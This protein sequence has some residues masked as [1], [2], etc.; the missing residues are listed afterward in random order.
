VRVAREL[1]A[2]ADAPAAVLELLAEDAVSQQDF[3]AAAGWYRRLTE[4]VPDRPLY[5]RNLYLML[6]NQGRSDDQVSVAR[7][8]LGHV[9]GRLELELDLASA[10]GDAGRYDEAIPRMRRIVE[11][12]PDNRSAYESLVSML[13][14]SGKAGEALAELTRNFPAFYKDY[15]RDLLAARMR[16]KLGEVEPAFELLRSMAEPSKGERYVP[17]LL[18]H[19]ISDHPRTLQTP[20]ALFEGQ[21]AALVSH[22]YRP[23]TLSELA[24]MLD[25]TVQFPARPVLVTFDDAR[26]DSLE[27]GDPILE[28]QG[29]KAT[30]FVPTGR[31]GEE[32][33]FHA[34]WSSLR[35]LQRAGRWELQAHGHDAHNPLVVDAA[36][37][38]GEFLAFHAWLPDQQRAENAAEFAS[39]I[40]KDYQRCRAA[41]E[42]HLPGRPIL[43]FAYP[44]NQVGQGDYVDDPSSTSVN[45]LV[46]RRYFRFGLIQDD[47]GYNGLS[48]DGIAPFMLRRFEVPREWDGRQLL[49]HLARSE[50]PRLARIEL[51]ELTLEDNRPEAA[52]RMLEA[53]AQSEPLV[54]PDVERRLAEVAW[55]EERP[56]E[57]A[58]HVRASAPLSPAAARS[59]TLPQRLAWR[60]DPSGGIDFRFFTD[61]DERSVLRLGGE[62][63]YPFPTQA[64]LELRAG[65]L[66]VLD[67]QAAV[68]SLSGVEVA[69][70][71]ALGLGRRVDVSGWGSYRQ[72]S[73]LSASVNGG[74]GLRLRAEQHALTLGWV[75]E[76]VD[77]VLAQLG[78]LRQHIISAGY[79][80]RTALWRAGARFSRTMVND[81]NWRNELHASALRAVGASSWRA[82]AGLDLEDSRF[83]P[84]AYYAPRQLAQAMARAQYEHTWRDASSLAAEVGLGGAH[85]A[86]HGIRPSG[87]AHVRYS[88]WW[89]SSARLGTGVD[90][91]ARLVPGYGSVGGFF[92]VD[93]RL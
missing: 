2:S 12:H 15:E 89:T 55:R 70:S 90:L 23:I 16:F 42:E 62:A 8:A 72:L 57:A 32:D 91:E 44:L 74:L 33:G 47:S 40:E 27:L 52:R 50:P 13:A 82:G 66:W 68:K 64:E 65:E 75:Y 58:L 1:A 86:G 49:A 20:A 24:R 77:T 4:R 71:A 29:I 41:L 30:M 35:R 43:G 36:G 6:G 56:R 69:S 18:Y 63:S 38:T 37:R 59:D 73:R 7:A 45:E 25:G 22:G 87:L 60:N 26:S 5:W 83:A 67:R 11:S 31:V 14:A 53:M 19:G 34:G 93:V 88:R 48:P 78:G 3:A 80:L 92:R 17:I 10:L 81:G 28:R 46:S 39:R 84:G 21:M 76:D 9:P 61:S 79:D 54:A 85:D 51:A